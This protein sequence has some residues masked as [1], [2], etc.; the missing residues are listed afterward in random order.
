MVYKYRSH[1]FICQIE[2]LAGQIGRLA[3][4]RRH[5]LGFGRVE[6]GQ[7]GRPIYLEQALRPQVSFMAIRSTCE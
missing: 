1:R 2:H 5:I 6:L 3:Y 7:T 4:E